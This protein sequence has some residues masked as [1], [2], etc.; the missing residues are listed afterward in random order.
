MDYKDYYE[1]LGVARD[2]SAD[3]IKKAYRRLARKYHPDVSTET[4]AAQRMA[5]INEANAVL[6][7]PEKRA[8]YDALGDAAQFARHGGFRQYPGD[9]SRSWQ[10][11]QGGASAQDFGAHFGHGSED[12]SSFF[13]DLFG[14]GPQFRRGGPPP[15]IRGQDQRAT[16]EMTVPESYSG[17][18]RVLHLRTVG[19]DAEGRAV[20][21]TRELEVNIPKGVRE[22]QLVR[23][24]GKGQPGVGHG[25]PGDLML[26]VRFKEDRRWRT[27]GKDVYQQLVL[28]PWEAALGGSLQVSTLGGTFDLNIPAASQHGRKLR[29]KGKGLPARVPGDLYLVVELSAPAP[30]NEVQREAYQVLARAFANHDPRQGD[31]A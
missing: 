29:I 11:P 28:A 5:E 6:S 18:S 15:D 8:E 16:I 2:A 21:S 20:E 1:I 17:T 31:A 12:F 19:L 25:K 23:L 10:G 26:E 24:A 22:G 4:D 9:G 13:E 27:E 7:D 3:E 30:R 14:R